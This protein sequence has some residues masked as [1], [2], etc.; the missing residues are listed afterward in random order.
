M[1]VVEVEGTEIAPEDATLEVGWISS[2]RNKQRKHAS[3]APAS[4]TG[5]GS[6][7][8]TPMLN[9]SAQRIPRKPRQPRLPDDH[10]KVVIR[11][12]NGLNLFKGGGGEAPLRDDI[13]CEVDLHATLLNEDIYHTCVE[14]N[15]IVVSTSH[16]SNA[17]IYSR[18]S[19]LQ[20]E[21]ETYDVRAYV[22]SPENTAKGV[23][24]NIPPYDSPE[25]ISASLVNDR[26]PRILQARRMGKTNFVLIV[27]DD[28]KVPFH[29]YYRG[30]EYK[31]YLH[32]KRTEVCDKCGAVGHRSDVCPKPNAVICTLCGTANPA[33]AHPRT[34]KC[35]LCVQAHQ[36][37]DKTCPQR[38][39]TPRLLIYR[40]QEKAK[41]QKQQYL[42]T[43]ISTQDAHPERQ[44]V[45]PSDTRSRSTSPTSKRRGSRSGSKQRR[46]N[47]PQELRLGSAAPEAPDG[48]SFCSCNP[49]SPSPPL[50]TNP[51]FTI[52]MAEQW[53]ALLLSTCPEDQLWPVRLVE[54][55]AKIQGLAAA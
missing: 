23:I 42:S 11:P 32:K 48:P 7:S 10:V 40:R 12:R 55:A 1:E 27:F 39:Q 43:M 47:Q 16:L 30:A 4:P 52:T 50:R 26:N 3:N 33:T 17:E 54:A 45:K 2:H 38:Y 44:E 36:T 8:D 25:D 9:G 14:A 35:L 13:L 37:G 29:V 31:C 5:Q 22:T 15:L 51:T 19:K 49:V 20:V 28:D 18:I 46:K 24:H 21:T 34:L 53:E 6:A 41:L